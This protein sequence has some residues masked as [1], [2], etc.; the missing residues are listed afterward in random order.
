MSVRAV[1]KNVSIAPRKVGEVVSLVRGRTVADAVT[2]LEHTPRRSAIAVRKVIQSAAANADYNHSYKIDTLKI[3]EIT[4]TPGQRYK[5]MR[6]AARGAALPYELKTS[7]ITVIVDGEKRQPK[8]AAA[9]KTA[10][11]EAK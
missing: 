1:A 8:K 9:K 10:T 5:R 7:H 11:K 6:P 4:V 3:T 2:I